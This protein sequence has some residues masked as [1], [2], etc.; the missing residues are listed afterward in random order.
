MGIGGGIVPGEQP[1]CCSFAR[2]L[3]NGGKGSV[4]ILSESKW[5]G[6][7]SVPVR[8]SF[9]SASAV[10]GDKQRCN[11]DQGRDAACRRPGMKSLKTTS[12]FA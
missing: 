6:T 1:P 2:C 10:H 3:F 12:N 9:S 7:Q 8:P 4:L 11:D 5:G